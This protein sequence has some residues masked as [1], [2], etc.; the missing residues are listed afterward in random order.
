M[1]GMALFVYIFLCLIWGTTWLATKF[2]LQ[3]MP[4]VW[5]GAI[6]M[7]LASVILIAYNFIARNRYP[8]GWKRRWYVARPGAIIFAA[9]YICTYSGMQYISSSLA[10]I[11]FAAMPFSV[12]L[13]AHY[14]LPD[15]K[16]NRRKLIGLVIGFAGIVVVFD[17]PIALT[18]DTLLGGGLVVGSTLISAFALVY[19]KAALPD[20]PIMPMISLQMATGAIVMTVAALALEDFSRLHMTMTAV[21]SVVYLAIFGSVIAF[22]GYFWLLRK[23]GALQVSLIAFVTPLV[24]V[25]IGAFA[26]DRLAGNEFLGAALVLAGVFLVNADQK[27]LEDKA[28]S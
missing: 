13:L 26:G 8:I 10:A 1:S 12:A 4:A 15:E 5:S 7:L 24:A 18:H 2:G 20:E 25:F 22:G 11:L 27:K 28:V 21:G 14:F 16:M 17:G 6:R 3:D 19:I 9:S 23:I